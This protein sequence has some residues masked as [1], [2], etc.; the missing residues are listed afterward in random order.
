MI[1]RKLTNS[2]ELVFTTTRIRK[3]LC[4]RLIIWNVTSPNFSAFNNEIDDS[5]E[6]LDF[7]EVPI[8]AFEDASDSE[9]EESLEQAVRNINE[10]RVFSCIPN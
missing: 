8:E 3:S 6:E 7:E 1:T 4:K 5:D 9:V 10:K 2:V